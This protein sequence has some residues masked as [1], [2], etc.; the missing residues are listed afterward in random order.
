MMIKT[1]DVG[2]GTLNHTPSLTVSIC[3][4]FTLYEQKLVFAIPASR[5]PGIP[6]S[7]PFS[8]IPN[9]G[10]SGVPIKGFRDYKNSLKLYCSVLNDTNNNSSPL[11]N[12]T[13][14]AR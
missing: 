10:I 8:P 9:P 14:D 11:I 7:R 3:N 5:I 13:F 6:G 4:C 12:K 1:N 2:G